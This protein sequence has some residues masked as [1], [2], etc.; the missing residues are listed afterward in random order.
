MRLKILV[1]NTLISGIAVKHL[2]T[3]I[4]KAWATLGLICNAQPHAGLAEMQSAHDLTAAWPL[5]HFPICMNRIRL[6]FFALVWPRLHGYNISL[7]GSAA[8]LA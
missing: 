5:L 7:C 2:H 4:R 1:A 6:R 3:F 8:I